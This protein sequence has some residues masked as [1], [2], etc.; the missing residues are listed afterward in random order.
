MV[1]EAMQL[2]K[3]ICSTS[4]G[5]ARLLELE[6]SI[7]ECGRDDAGERSSDDV[8]FDLLTLVW[9]NESKLWP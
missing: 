6:C 5:G 1:D 9:V 4:Q 7:L 3:M 8:E 2:D